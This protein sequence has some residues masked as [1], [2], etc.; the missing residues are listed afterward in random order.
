MK[1]SILLVAAA[2]LQKN[3]IL[4]ILVF[5]F[6]ITV[7]SGTLLIQSGAKHARKDFSYQME[8]FVSH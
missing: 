5:V 1:L 6:R 8:E 7:L 4:L 2:K 3:T